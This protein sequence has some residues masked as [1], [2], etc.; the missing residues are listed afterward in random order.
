MAILTMSL[1][2]RSSLSLLVPTISHLFLSSHWPNGFHVH[3]PSYFLEIRAGQA[4]VYVFNCG[5]HS[6][7]TGWWWGWRW[8]WR[9]GWGWCWCWCWCWDRAWSWDSWRGWGGGRGGGGGGSQRAFCCR[10]RREASCGGGPRSAGLKCSPH[11]PSPLFE[12]PV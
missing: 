9:W 7:W 1:F 12:V 6:H 8:R 5:G 2:M 4:E 10:Q 3:A 11:P